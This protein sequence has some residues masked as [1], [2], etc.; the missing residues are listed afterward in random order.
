MAEWPIK[1]TVRIS[2]RD[3]SLMNNAQAR[4]HYRSWWSVLRTVIFTLALAAIAAWVLRSFMEISVERAF[5][6]A[7]FG[8][9]LGLAVGSR[10]NGWLNVKLYYNGYRVEKGDQHI[11]ISEEGLST[12]T[13]SFSGTFPWL[14]FHSIMRTDEH[15]LF[16][17]N[18]M[19]AHVLP[20]RDLKDDDIERVWDLVKAMPS[21]WRLKVWA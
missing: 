9:V 2:K 13:E 12:K 5:G 15:F 8:A 7:L 3:Y 4:L 17:L 14:A 16:W 21:A 18:P 10:F 6:I 1:A 19:Q 11:E 20:F